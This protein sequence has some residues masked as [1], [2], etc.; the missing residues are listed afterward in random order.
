MSIDPLKRLRRSLTLGGLL[1]WARSYLLNIVIITNLRPSINASQ[2]RHTRHLRTICQA[3][4][5]SWPAFLSTFV[6]SVALMNTRGWSLLGDQRVI[7]A[8]YIEQRICA[9]LSDLNL[10]NCSNQQ[11]CVC[12]VIS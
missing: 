9:A 3:Y 5:S 10:P 12:W 11:T 6:K 2:N 7:V 1:L 8:F 4:K